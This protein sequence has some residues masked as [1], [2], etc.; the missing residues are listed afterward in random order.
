MKTIFELK[1]CGVVLVSWLMDEHKVFYVRQYD[2]SGVSSE[3]VTE[4]F[5]EAWSFYHDLCIFKI[6]DIVK[7][8]EEHGGVD[9]LEFQD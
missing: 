5:Q 3:V 2:S 7:G 6:P 9:V 1:F 4:D 8:I